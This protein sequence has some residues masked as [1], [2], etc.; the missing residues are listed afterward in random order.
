MQIQTL[1]PLP[2]S[3][4]TSLLHAALLKAKEKC[5]FFRLIAAYT[6]Y[7]GSWG[8]EGV[9]TGKATGQTVKKSE[10]NRFFCFLFS[11]FCCFCIQ[12]AEMRRFNGMIISRQLPFHL[13][14]G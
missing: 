12:R 8:A 6:M 4:P 5:Y 1:P 3:S 14:Y 10:E 9:G 11:L 7:V 13:P 2:S